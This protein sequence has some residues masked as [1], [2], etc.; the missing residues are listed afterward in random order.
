MN[1]FFVTA[2]AEKV[3]AQETESYFREHLARG[4]EAACEAW[5][6]HSPSVPLEIGDEILR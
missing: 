2:I 1:Q 5:Q 4:E 6:A 3:F